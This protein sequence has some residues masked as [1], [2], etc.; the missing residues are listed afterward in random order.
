MAGLVMCAVIVHA[1]PLDLPPNAIGADTFFV[2]KLNPAGIDPAAVEATFKAALG[3]DAGQADKLLEGFKLRH[4]RF[5]SKGVDTV[6]VVMR[7]DPNTPQGPDPIFYAKMKPDA[8]RAALEKMVRDELG[9]A[10]ADMMDVTSDG[11]FMLFRKKGVEAPTDASDERRK[12]F[13]EALG[14]SNKPGVGALICT[15]AMVAGVQR[16]VQHGAPEGLAT[17]VNA[18]KWFR[19]EVTLGES[20]KAEVIIHAADADGGKQIADGLTSLGNAMKAQ[21]AIIKNAGGKATAAA[22]NIETVADVMSKAEQN[23]ENVAVTVD[24]KAIGMMLREIVREQKQDAG[25]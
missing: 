6:T 22:E 4:E 3:D 5:S 2:A 25:Q 14:D 1:A 13:E 7:G 8:D 20:P 12:L 24:S 21:A 11:D 17:L 10:N 15:E 9:E 23:N 16:D 19:F 18:G